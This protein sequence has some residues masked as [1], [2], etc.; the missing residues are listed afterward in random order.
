M[1]IQDITPPRNAFD[2]LLITIK[3]NNAKL[4]IIQ[5]KR[6]VVKEIK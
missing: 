6:I 2:R 5:G 4:R 1:T 3:A